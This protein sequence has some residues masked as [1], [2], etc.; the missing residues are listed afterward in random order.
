MGKDW[1]VHVYR[2]DTEEEEYVGFFLDEAQ[3][4]AWVA[5]H[6]GDYEVTNEKP[7][8]RKERADV[9]TTAG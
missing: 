3:A 4:K 9:A 2:T 7:G 5:K 8:A 1:N 6:E